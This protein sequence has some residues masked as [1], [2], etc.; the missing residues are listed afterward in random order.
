MKQK[1]NFF[2][3]VKHKEEILFIGS[4]N[5]YYWYC[6]FLIFGEPNEIYIAT[7]NEKCNYLLRSFVN[8]QDGKNRIY[9][10]IYKLESNIQRDI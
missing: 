8:W 1:Y 7:S 6:H 9:V 4:C 3:A 5:H 10:L 2:S